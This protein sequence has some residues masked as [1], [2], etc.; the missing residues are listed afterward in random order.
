MNTPRI[1][2][3]VEGLLDGWQDEPNPMDP[4]TPH[5]PSQPGSGAN[6]FG[7]FGPNYPH[8]PSPNSRNTT[9][10]NVNGVDENGSYGPYR[11]TEEAVADAHAFLAE[12]GETPYD[13][14]DGDVDTDL[15]HA[16]IMTDSYTIDVDTVPHFEQY[17]RLS[18]Q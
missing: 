11:S 3:L 15:G 6:D 17:G 1:N 2:K 5:G 4:K 9:W 13:T 16:T 12:M 8:R 14:D 10:L 18:G 7:P